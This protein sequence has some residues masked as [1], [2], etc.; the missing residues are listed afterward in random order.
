[1]TPLS[2]SRERLRLVL[3]RPDQWKS[4]RM[5]YGMR[6]DITRVLDALDEAGRV[7][8]RCKE[9]F[10]D[11]G[12]HRQNCPAAPVPESG[13]AEP[14]DSFIGRIEEIIAATPTTDTEKKDG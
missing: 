11:R 7:V 4:I 10:V 1:M 2:E 5:P 9:C 6:A 8:G 14:A 12:F 13:P 3:D